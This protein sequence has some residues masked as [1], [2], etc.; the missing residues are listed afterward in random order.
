[1]NEVE[2]LR[3]TATNFVY[4][5]HTCFQMSYIQYFSSQ[6]VRTQI[7]SLLRDP[8]ANDPHPLAIRAS[9]D[10][11]R[12]LE[13][14]AS[15]GGKMFGVL[16]VA[17]PSGRL[18]YLSGFSGMLNKQW[19]VSGFV[20]PV[21]D[22]EQQSS[23]LPVGEARVNE[24]SAEINSCLQAP[25]RL[26]AIESLSALE[27]KKDEA[28]DWI[29][30][31]NKSNKKSR[32]QQRN[33]I[34]HG[35]GEEVIE[36]KL[37]ALASRSQRDKRELLQAK[38]YWAQRIKFVREQLDS[39]Y[40]QKIEAL[41][42]QRTVLSQRLHDQ[43]FDSYQLMNGRSEKVSLKSLFDGDIPPAGAADC[44]AP[45]LI[46]FAHQNRLA[47]LALAEFWW[48]PSPASGVRYHGHFYPPCRGKCHPILPHMLEGVAT[49]PSNKYGDLESLVPVVVFED[50]HLLVV[51]KPA[52]L[53]SVPGKSVKDSVFSWLRERYVHATGPLLVHRLDGGTSGLL[54]VA[55]TSDI[56]KRLQRQ[57]IDRTIKKRYVAVLSKV[58]SEQ[59]ISIDLPLRVDLD[60]RPRQLVCYEHGKH[61]LTHMKLLSTD[62]GTS[63]V[64]FYPVTGRTHQLRVHAAHV[65]GLAAP[66]V[67]D[68]L[69]GTRAE[70]MLL[71]AEKLSFEHP[72]TGER[73]DIQAD[74]PF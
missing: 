53:L 58:V 9:K 57:F 42:S 47:I 34:D 10:L 29:K 72:I 56:H 60:D 21:F 4:T 52:G 63:R 30:V 31:Q 62:N 2:S 59:D 69:Y 14:R 17:D 54:L 55:K 64:H 65:D 3:S 35:L 15:G 36:R 24:L 16:V 12:R 27:N 61:A 1:M 39:E 22:R 26:L 66:I 43:V 51:N 73:M 6:P 71:H 68:S 49:E 13:S 50:D 32:Q 28:L 44:A 46:Q 5:R 74:A 25:D 70:R 7:P 19:S 38:S 37:Q 48:G 11:Q 33:D 45:K 67:G 8:F 41:F 40:E 23:F 18:G 20:P